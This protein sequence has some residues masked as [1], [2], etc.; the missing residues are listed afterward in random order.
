MFILASN[1]PRRRE[2]LHQIGLDDFIIDPAKGEETAPQGLTPGE[3]VEHLALQKALEVARRHENDLILAADTIVTVE[4]KVM[5]KPADE[6]DAR[7]MLRALSGRQSPVYTGVALCKGEKALVG[8][9]CTQVFF[10]EMKEEEICW[11]VAD[12]EPLDKAGA[13]GIQGKGARFI[14]RI[15]GDYGNVVGL[16]LCRVVTMMEEFL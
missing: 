13:Y 7:R 12:G 4:G 16:P 5:G 3:L 11:Y 15:E 10:R 2:L 6:E 1:S 8:H 9:E 14:S